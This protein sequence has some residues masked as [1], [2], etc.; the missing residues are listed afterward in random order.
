MLRKTQIT[1]IATLLTWSGTA[2]ATLNILEDVAEAT[3]S[4]ATLPRH[5]ADQVV[6]RDC[7]GCEAM[8]WR[9]NS[10]T[11]YFVGMNTQAVALADLRSAAA[12]EQDKMLYVFFKPGTDEVT[13]LI[14]SLKH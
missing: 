13:R 1:L 3:V 8:I 4:G 10:G 12:N 9:V 6:V 11:R 14:L 5:A 7:A 2:V